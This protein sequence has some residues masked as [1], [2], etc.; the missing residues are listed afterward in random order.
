M[1]LAPRKLGRAHAMLIDMLVRGPQI[2]A[3]CVTW[4]REA[5]IS[6][7]TLHEAR[8]RLPVELID[9]I[10]D[11]PGW[12]RLADE[13]GDPPQEWRSRRRHRCISCGT[14][15][16]GLHWKLKRCRA[17]G[18]RPSSEHPFRGGSV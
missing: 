5:S 2:V 14:S 13:P 9:R 1:N 15:L 16:E 18:G 3:S 11:G 10:G 4:A 12:W 8:R 7:R 17:C 6:A